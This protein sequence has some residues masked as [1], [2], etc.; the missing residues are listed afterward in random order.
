MCGGVGEG[1]SG[2]VASTQSGTPGKEES[3]NVRK[4]CMKVYREERGP[5]IGM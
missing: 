5:D 3:R 2:L 1:S 4:I